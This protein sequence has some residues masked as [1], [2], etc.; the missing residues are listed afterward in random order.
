[1]TDDARWMAGSGV[2]P[3]GS[4]LTCSNLRATSDYHEIPQNTGRI[5]REDL[6]LEAD[7][8]LGM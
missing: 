2:H 1:M 6:K 4:K 3:L 8:K 7:R 5:P